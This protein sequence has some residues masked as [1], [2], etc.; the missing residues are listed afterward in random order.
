MWVRA[1]VPALLLVLAV[2]STGCASVA[3]LQEEGDVAGLVKIAQKP[4]QDYTKVTDAVDAI[5]EIGTPEAV[6]VLIGWVSGDDDSLRIAAIPALGAAGDPAGVEPL[7]AELAALDPAD[8]STYDMDLDALVRAL[9]GIKDPRAA[10]TLFELVDSGTV[11][12]KQ[13]TTLGRA[14]AAQGTDILAELV[15]RLTRKDLEVSMPCGVAL[16]ILHSGDPARMSALLR[17]A[18]TQRVW[19]GVFS[20]AAASKYQTDLVVALDKFGDRALASKML[21]SEL[22]GLEQAARDWAGKHGYRVE[23]IMQFGVTP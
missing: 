3:K 10:A 22:P 4:G 7:A 17:A 19:A 14:L 1:S 9:G 6:E 8:A 5:G 11:S 16:Y 13:A 21:N 23:E 18:E 2:T 20:E 12:A 15:P